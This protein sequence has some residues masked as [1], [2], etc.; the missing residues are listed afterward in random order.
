MVFAARRTMNSSR[1]CAMPPCRDR[2][3]WPRTSPCINAAATSRLY[4]LTRR[5]SDTV[6]ASLRS[7][8]TLSISPSVAL[9]R[10]NHRG[11]VSR[12]RY[13]ASEHFS[14]TMLA[15]C[16]KPSRLSSIEVMRIK[17]PRYTR[18]IVAIAL[19]RCFHVCN[20]PRIFPAATSF[21]SHD[22]WRVRMRAIAC[23]L[24]RRTSGSTSPLRRPSSSCCSSSVSSLRPN[25]RASKN[26]VG[27]GPAAAS[28]G[29]VTRNRTIRQNSDSTNR[30]SFSANSDSGDSRTTFLET[31][32]GEMN[33]WAM[34]RSCAVTSPSPS[35]PWS[36]SSSRSS[37]HNSSGSDLATSLLLSSPNSFFSLNAAATDGS[38]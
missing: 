29:R 5:R 34:Y 18:C 32:I 1:I 16:L 2:T 35:C 38:S 28:R 31:D 17:W 9:S 33:G 11:V 30:D 8:S 22:G 14:S 6:S 24:A 25:A 10:E 23:R 20:A 19:R 13:R 3:K 7:A 26:A 27:V 15:R 37:A 36:S 12:P 21:A 4:S